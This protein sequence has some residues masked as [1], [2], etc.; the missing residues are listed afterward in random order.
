MNIE[1]KNFRFLEDQLP[2]LAVLADFAE[3]YLYTDPS[4]ALVKLRSFIEKSAVNQSLTLYNFSY[5][6]FKQEAHKLNNEK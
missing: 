5:L 4:S 3:Q 1:S 2:E 6:H